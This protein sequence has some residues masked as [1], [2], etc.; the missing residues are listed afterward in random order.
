MIKYNKENIVEIDTYPLSSIFPVEWCNWAY[1]LVR[2]APIFCCH[3]DAEHNLVD[4]MDLHDFLRNALEGEDIQN[5]GE[6][7]DLLDKLDDEYILV[8]IMQ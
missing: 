4:P 3:E 6:V 5:T 7:L 1:K 2:E 8:D